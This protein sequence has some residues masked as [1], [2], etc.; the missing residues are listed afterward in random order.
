MLFSDYL[1]G[2]TLQGCSFSYLSEFKIWVLVGTSIDLCLSSEN[3]EICAG[4][5]VHK[6]VPWIMQ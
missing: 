6:K 1:G 3:N 2:E 4:S 5:R